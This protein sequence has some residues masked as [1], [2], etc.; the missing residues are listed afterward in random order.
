VPGV[1]DEDRN[2]YGQLLDRAVERGL[3]GPSDYEVRL[4]E[5]AEAS[6]LEQMNS[7]VTEL[8]AF[9]PPSTPARSR[10]ASLATAVGPAP[11]GPARRRQSPWLLL[12]I[13]I[14]VVAASLVFLALY[15]GHL[16]RSRNSGLAPPA[17]A[18]RA[19]SAPR[20]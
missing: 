7:I 1:T 11:P 18:A 6:T 12:V 19:L 15:A 16:V 10:S 5:L 3:L 8:P 13:V 2:R 20:L 17:V 14:V 4:R 9:A